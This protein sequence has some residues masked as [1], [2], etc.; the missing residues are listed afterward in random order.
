MQTVGE[1][2]K[3]T[4]TVIL[5]LYPKEGLAEVYGASSREAHVIMFSHKLNTTLFLG[6]TN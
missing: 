5:Q 1:S 6:V 2:G 4:F 3:F